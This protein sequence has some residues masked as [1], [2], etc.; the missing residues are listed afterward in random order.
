MLSRQKA[1]TEPS[2][3]L[4][5]NFEEFPSMS[6]FITP[7]PL[8]TAA[9]FRGL[10]YLSLCTYN[11]YLIIRAFAHLEPHREW[12]PGGAS[13]L[14]MEM[15]YENNQYFNLLQSA[16]VLSKNS[17]KVEQYNGCMQPLYPIW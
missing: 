3:V 16:V 7:P 4:F 6:I 12:P 5:E 2:S 8:L 14:T 10:F 15:H 13:Y 9:L 1:A 17:K 11:I